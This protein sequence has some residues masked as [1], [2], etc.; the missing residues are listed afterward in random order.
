VNGYHIESVI[1]VS[2]PGRAWPA[3]NPGATNGVKALSAHTCAVLAAFPFSDYRNFRY[4]LRCGRYRSLLHKALH[5]IA[6]L[7]KGSRRNAARGLPSVGK[8]VRW[9]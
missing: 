3:L 4:A 2:P 7:R 9:L 1:K 5:A 6:L 8:V